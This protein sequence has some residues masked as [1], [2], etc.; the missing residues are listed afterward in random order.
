MIIWST[1]ILPLLLT[2]SQYFRRPQLLSIVGDGHAIVLICYTISQI[3][4]FRSE[5]AAVPSAKVYQSGAVQSLCPAMDLTWWLQSSTIKSCG[6]YGRGKSDTSKPDVM[7]PF[8]S[9]TVIAGT[10]G[11]ASLCT[12]YLRKTGL[13]SGSFREVTNIGNIL[14]A[15]IPKYC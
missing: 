13:P 6:E 3:V 15:R 12:R 1:H 7:N 10:A 2:T 5:E 11:I 14:F 8:N 4:W 9:S